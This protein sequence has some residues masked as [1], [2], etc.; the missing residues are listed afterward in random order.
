MQDLIY[1]DGDIDADDDWQTSASTSTVF[2]QHEKI[3]FKTIQ[4]QYT[5]FL[6]EMR[7]QHMLPQGIIQNITTSI[8]NLFDMT[9][10]LIEEKA[11][12]E[13]INE[14]QS[15][16]T[17]I[18]TNSI[19]KTIKKI[20]E[21]I[22]FST[23]NEYQF[24][25]SCKSFFDYTPPIENLIS[26]KDEKKEY[27]YHVSIKD[28]LKK[29]LEK[30]EMIPLLINNIQDQNEITQA[31]SD[32]MFSF[33]HGIR[34]NKINK[35]SFLIQLYVDGIGVTN[36]I[37]PRKGLHNITMVYFLLEDIPDIF[38]STLQC[39]NL[40][41]ICYT[42][43]LNNNEKMKKFY[44]PIVNDLNGL[45]STGL[46]INTFNSQ[47][48]FTF[49][50]IAAD[51]LAAHEVAGFQETFSSGHFCQRCLISYENRLV[52][53]ADVDII[54]RVNVKH[55]YYLQLLN[56]LPSRKSVFGV[57]GPSPFDEL[58]NFDPTQ[59]FPGDIMH[60]FFE[61]VCPLIVIAMLKEA[62]NL[63]LITYAGIQERTESFSY[64]AFDSLDRP[65]PIQVKHFHKN[66]IN[67]TAAQKYCLFRL[68]PIVFADIT[69]RLKTFKIYLVLREMLDMVLALPV[70]KSWLPYIETLAIS[71]QKEQID[72]ETLFYMNDFDLL[73]PFKLSYKNQLLFLTEREKLFLTKTIKESPT[74]SSTTHETTANVVNDIV[75]ETSE[76]NDVVQLSAD[77]T[78]VTPPISTNSSISV[79]LLPDPYVVPDLPDQVKHAITNK[80]M[81]KFEKL[82][83]F[84]SI[85]ID[86][87]FYD[88]KTNYDLIYPTK[89]QYSTIVN[90]LLNHL[91]VEYD[92]KKMNSWRESLISKFKRERQNLVNDEV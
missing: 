57:V 49:T 41:A 78:A 80:E 25:K 51:N 2:Q 10:D 38:R 68:F 20:E 92:T 42:K 63:K 61:G 74:S 90:G 40:A 77:L 82:C 71:F 89:T 8:L 19:R 54:P 70:R 9:I 35:K 58:I 1:E 86:A 62:S 60:D 34:G 48:Y 65:Q 84:R 64:G 37:G 67:G 75:Q 27:S 17:M 43:Y 66:C 16:T 7:E 59:C 44:A 87:I 24:I 56:E 29:I 72:G 88:L 4:K 6:L 11:K 26:S 5:L 39:I 3:T 76:N 32:L 23:K 36:P 52:S 85:V 81:E 45:Q 12:E 91:G 69:A 55:Q 73:K 13:N 53:L 28:S 18:S 83:N 15:S 22:T 47:I 21:L 33:R 14:Q 31:D 30:D 79:K 50:T 46:I